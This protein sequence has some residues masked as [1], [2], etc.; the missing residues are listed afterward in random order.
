MKSVKTARGR[1]LDMG[2][3]SAKNEETRAVSNLNM[4][5]RGDIIDNRNEVT[6]PREEIAKKF[7]KNNVPGADEE[8]I[9][10]KEDENPAEAKKPVDTPKP[11]PKKT[12][13]PKP[14]PATNKVTEVSRT[15]RTRADGSQY[16]EVEYSDGS[17][18]DIEAGG[19]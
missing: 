8:K 4:N 6:I 13:T 2:A 18:E 14:A 16:F 7:Y 9:S 10:I 15:A 11:A 17:M 3:L 1:T 12:A 19:K 5:A